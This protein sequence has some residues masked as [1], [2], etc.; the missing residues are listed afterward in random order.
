[1][2]EA[3]G[4]TKVVSRAEIRNLPEKRQ[5][6]LEYAPGGHQQQGGLQ[7]GAWTVPPERGDKRGLW[8]VKHAEVAAEKQGDGRRSRTA[9][10]LQS[11]WWCG[12]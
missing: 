2:L 1:M 11:G 4:E 10:E 5:A 8:Q 3:A 9:G 7:A 6:G 12:M